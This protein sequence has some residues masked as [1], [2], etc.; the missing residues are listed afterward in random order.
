[1][2]KK[3]KTSDK[4]KVLQASDFVHLH[5]HTQYSLLDGLTKVPKLIDRVK[6][7]GMEA[8]AMTDHGTLSGAVEFY[9]KAREKGVKPVIGIEAYIAPRKY[10]DKDPAKD[11]QYFHLTILAMN[12]KGYQNLMRLST[13][14]NLE[15]FYY[16]PRIDRELLQKY[17]EGLIVLSGCINGEFGDAIRQEQIEQAEETAKWYKSVFG[18]RYYIE[19]QDHGHPHH[20]SAWDEQIKVTEASFKIAKKLDIPTAITGDAHYLQKDDQEA[21]EILLCVQTGAFLSDEDRMS[22]EE[23]ELYVADPKD[24]IKR[25]GKDYPDSVKNTR[26]IADRCNVELK[27]GEYLI[28]KFPVPKGETEKSYLEILTYK[29]LLSR[30]APKAKSTDDLSAIKKQLDKEVV[31]RAEFELQV[32]ERM[33]FDGY[34]LIV[35]DFI[36]WGKDQG[37][38][39]GP[40]RGSGAGSIVAYGLRIT[41]LDPLKYDLLFERFLNPDRI[42]MPDFDVDIQDT[43]RDEVIQYCVEKYGED[44]VANIVT[45]GTMAARNAVR[46]VA[47]VLQVPY[48]EADRLAKMIPPPVQGRHI[49]LSESLKNNTDLKKEYQD[50]DDAKRVFDLAMKLEGTIRS[51]GVHAAG[52]VIAPDDIVK[53]TPL[54]KAQKGVIATQYSMVPIEKIGLLKMDFLGLSNLTIINN[55]LR[56]IRKVYGEEIDIGEIPLDDEKTFK[57]LQRGDTTGV[58][59]LESAGMKRYLKDLRP[60]EFADIIAMN[61]LYRPGPMSEIPR[62][63]AGKNDPSTISYPHPSLEPILKNTYGVMVFQEQII[64]MLQLLAG[65]KPGEAD[66]VRKAIGKKNRSIMQSEKPRFMEGC[67]KKGL[68]KKDAEKVWEQIQPFA[69]YSFNKAH[70]ACY[71]MIAYQTAYLKAHFPAAFM[72][73]LMTSDYDDTDRLAIEISECNSMGIEVLPPDVNESFGEFGV[74]HSKKS[75]KIRFGMNAIKNVGSGAVEEIIRAREEL[76]GFDNLESFLSNTSTRAVNRKAL[77]SLAKS[78]ALDGFAERDVIVENLDGMLAFAN[79]RQKDMKSGQTDLFGGKSENLKIRLQ[80]SPPAGKLTDRQK[81]AWERELLGIYLSSHP[82]AEY[83]ET[84]KNLA[85]PIEEA[86]NATDEKRLTIGGSVSD[87]KDITTKNGKRMAFVR[88]ADLSGEI[89]LVIFPGVID[90]TAGL[91]RRDLVLLVSGKISRRGQNGNNSEPK[92]IVDSARELDLETYDMEEINGTSAGTYKKPDPRVYVRIPDTDDQDALAS[93]KAAIDETPGMVPVVLVVGPDDDKQII[94][95][96]TLVDPN[97]EFLSTAR[98]I[99]GE[100]SIKYQ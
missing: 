42:S 79:R 13:I 2:P 19:I 8:I 95:I 10:T 70:A 93:L 88:L 11:K 81:V 55:T 29:G 75:E 76:G 26:K 47:R 9:T 23:F 78:G 45:F 4:N 100:T 53:F 64:A 80:L 54:E 48:A 1:M 35:Q 16:K 24:I 7:M 32:I 86:M 66:L 92:I 21:H 28:P 15:G 90:S 12:N 31:K 6:E 62:F 67:A 89:E 91:W 84:L 39:F 33:G 73:A 83:E 68:S 52:V 27:L 85:V 56:I 59:Q 44:R 63:I 94:K 36:N 87:V 58:F 82:L 37:I 40:G 60:T 97:E 46:D 69:D 22:L 38:V 41:E 30:Y 20:T 74:I 51:H 61:A 17:N 3:E 34:F 18:D 65:Y 43:R 57:L 25:W 96:P 50:N 72:A 14:S 98:E 77:E 49:P 99:F 71:A 5:N